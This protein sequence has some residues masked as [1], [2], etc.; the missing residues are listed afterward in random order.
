MPSGVIR[1]EIGRNGV[2][3]AELNLSTTKCAAGRG[4]KYGLGSTR[5][6]ANEIGTLGVA[7]DGGSPPGLRGSLPRG[8]GRIADSSLQ[9]TNQDR[10]SRPAPHPTILILEW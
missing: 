2:S 4:A 6:L 1:L 5:A 3:Y 9:I 10:S 8:P 7:D